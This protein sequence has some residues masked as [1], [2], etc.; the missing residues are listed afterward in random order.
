M[1][2]A[3]PNIPQ[4]TGLIPD[5]LLSNI[6]KS[7]RA[8][9][10]GADL[11][12][13]YDS[14]PP[15]RPELAQALAK[16]YDLPPGCSWPETVQSYLYRFN[17][18]RGG[19][20]AFLHN[21]LGSALRPGPTHQAIAR[22]GFRAIVTAWYD[23]LLEQALREAGCRVTR[24]VRN[25]SEAYTQEGE[26]EVVVVKL[27]GCL[28]RGDSLV[29]S[30]REHDELMVQLDRTLELVTGFCQAR[31]LLFVGF[32]LADSTP[33]LLYTRALINAVE[34]DRRAFVVWPHPLD[35][36]Q[37]A[38]AGRNVVFITAQTAPFLESLSSQLP[39]VVSGGKGAIRVNR[40]PFKFLDYYE[41]QD[42][43]IF[44]GRDIESQI[45]ARLILSHRLLTLFGPSGAGKTSLLLAGVLPRLAAESYQHVYVRALD[46]P[47]LAVRKAIAARA[48]QSVTDGGSLR[49]F[50]AAT[51]R[52]GVPASSSP[53]T[54]NQSLGYRA[55]LRQI[56]IE[57][58][59]LDELRMLCFDLGVE[60]ESLS[61][62]TRDGKAM[63]LI[64]HL[65]HRLRLAE[66]VALGRRIRPD[67]AWNDLTRAETQPVAA[68]LTA[69][70]RLV[71]VLDQFEE[72]FLRVGP[73]RR[74][75]F[76]RELADALDKPERDVR[77]VFSLREDYFHRLDEAREF[78]PD[79]FADSRRL[80]TLDRNHAR[81]AITEPA[82]RAGVTV[83]PALV[84]ALVGGEGRT[85]P[86]APLLQGE[87]SASPFP[88]AGGVG[89]GDLVEADG[90]VPPAALQIV[91][92]RL[93]REALPKGHHPSNPPPP[94]V[95][96]TLAAYRAI[97]HVVGQGE[98][99]Q[100]VQG[101]QAILA[102]YVNEGLARLPDLKREDG[103][104]P[105][106]ADKELGREILKVMV[107]SQKTKSV[108]THEELLAG[109]D[110]AGAI[111]RDNPRDQVRVED[112]RLGLER[113]RLV[114]GFER[115]GAACYELAHDHL[116]AEIAAWLGQE[117]MQAKMAR[118]ILRRALDNWKHAR[119]LVPLDALKLIQA[120][121]E[122]LR[123]L[124]P[125]ELELVFRSALAHGY[126]TTYWFGRARQAGA[127]ADGIALEGLKSSSFR[128]R[129][130]AVNALAQL[131]A[132]FIQPIIEML[133]DEYP[134]VRVAAIGALE[135]LQPS[136][137]WRTRLKYECH[138]PAGKFIMGEAEK[139][140]EVY[141]DAFYI[142]KYPV[143]NAE[144]KRYMDD[145]DQ[146]WETPAGK[147][148]HPV[149]NVSWYQ[150]RNYARWASMRLLTEAEWEKA[151]SWEEGR[152]EKS[153]ER[154]AKGL[155]RLVG[156]RAGGLAE[157]PGG[158]KRSYPW[159]GEF[160]KT[161]CNTSESGIGTTTPVGKYSPQGDSP[162]GCADM[163]GNVWEWTSSLYKD[164][165]YEADDG[166]EDMSLSDRRVLRGGSFY[167][168][169]DTARAASRYNN[170]PD[171]EW[172]SDGFRCGCGAAFPISL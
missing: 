108:L 6:N 110:E 45:V 90:R 104:T 55:Q 166:R 129:A 103:V 111:Q 117:E 123:Q 167:I 153:V 42:A 89:G 157:K 16:Q 143:T 53:Q 63:A 95:R 150:S 10:L 82:A 80:M 31:P 135:K 139:A 172:N 152:G 65:E 56:L 39:A 14:A 106:G 99:A 87:G 116:A 128:T 140:H 23:E 37:A 30:A 115:E 4:P 67:I 20:L 159:E 160:D 46:D 47:L 58:F 86:P 147:A 1:E 142:G 165:P 33:R 133:A 24:V 163:A 44:C 3:M 118:E 32:D 36:V 2:Y 11:P 151:A 137:E 148:D 119:L 156:R 130:A 21:H 19:L 154:G 66:L 113:V 68:P 7:E 71:V 13:G 8:L 132:Q 164:Y 9:F 141:V 155:Q 92:D 28:D 50:L 62:A 61:G 91:L 43:D 5:E 122:D 170:G 15:S 97:R 149:V 74:A 27:Y 136:G 134:Q 54:E 57:R 75:D 96:L 85:S 78:F 48:G 93:Y 162:Y 69:S 138:V 79:I 107:T 98:E 25:R 12:L 100:Q 145:I 72:L 34:P 29:L 169:E 126:E 83:E 144:Y 38:W 131:G 22:A 59:K 109:L 158:K 64:E 35:T 114:R 52:A 102:G 73:L 112:T 51:L 26:R 18:D 146:P 81:V 41:P 127:P 125:E 70:D 40:P 94:G 49:A 101:A 77:F 88:L 60:Y 17:N 76:F 168:N 171:Y 84:D 124:R 161:R 105:L 121:C 120:C